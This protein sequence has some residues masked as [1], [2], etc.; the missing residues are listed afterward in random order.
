M[1]HG[2]Y[3]ISYKCFPTGQPVVE[4]FIYHCSS[5]GWTLRRFSLPPVKRYSGFKALMVSSSESVNLNLYLY[6]SIGIDIQFHFFSQIT[7][8]GTAVNQFHKAIR[9]NLNLVY[10][11][12]RQRN[13]HSWPEALTS[14]SKRIETTKI[15]QTFLHRAVGRFVCRYKHLFNPVRL[16]LHSFIGLAFEIV[17]YLYLFS[18]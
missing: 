2:R 17:K 7:V 6:P 10:K 8:T 4:H 14:S 9:V 3:K 18:S 5:A 13:A 15:R 11:S 1:F 12:A 16:A